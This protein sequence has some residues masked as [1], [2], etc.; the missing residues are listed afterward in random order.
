MQIGDGIKTKAF[1]GLK[2]DQLTL[3]YKASRAFVLTEYPTRNVGTDRLSIIFFDTAACIVVKGTAVDPGISGKLVGEAFLEAT[4][5][6][7]ATPLATGMLLDG[8]GVI[9]EAFSTTSG[10]IRSNGPVPIILLMSTLCCFANF[11]A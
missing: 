9:P 7:A 10:V 3:S 11:F 5:V 2:L 4:G 6:G 1:E 8:L